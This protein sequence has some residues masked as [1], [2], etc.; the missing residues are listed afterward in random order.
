MMMTTHHIRGCKRK[1]HDEEANKEYGEVKTE[2][3]DLNS[4]YGLALIAFRRQGDMGGKIIMITLY[5][6]M[7]PRSS[8]LCNFATCFAS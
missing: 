5:S 4:K 1:Q 6:I 3:V 7:Y 8:D 2:S